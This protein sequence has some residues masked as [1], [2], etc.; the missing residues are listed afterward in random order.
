MERSLSALEPFGAQ[1]R[2]QQVNEQQQGDQ[3]REQN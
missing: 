3:G 1:Q 2:R